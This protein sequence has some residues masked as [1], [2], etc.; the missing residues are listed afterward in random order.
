MLQ[1]AFPDT[2]KP[3]LFATIISLEPGLIATEPELNAT[4]LQSSV[5]P[6][7]LFANKLNALPRQSWEGFVKKLISGFYR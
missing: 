4:S 7:G 6:L 3:G 5:S 2:F 1:P